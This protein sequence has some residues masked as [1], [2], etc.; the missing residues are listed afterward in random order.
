MLSILSHNP[1]ISFFGSAYFFSILFPFSPFSRNYL[2]HVQKGAKKAE[3][4]PFWIRHR[5]PRAFCCVRVVQKGAEIA[6]SALFR[7]WGMNGRASGEVALDLA[8]FSDTW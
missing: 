1:S 6:E 3:S 2:F 4:A 8:V 5:P 7:I